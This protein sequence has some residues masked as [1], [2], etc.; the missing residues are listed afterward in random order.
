M[1]GWSPFYF[2]GGFLIY[3]IMTYKFYGE[4]GTEMEITPDYETN[5]LIICIE[6]RFSQTTITLTDWDTN[7]LVEVLNTF[8]KR[9]TTL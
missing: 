3:T 7:E 2:D 1:K 8:K 5:G 6:G 9:Q 4:D